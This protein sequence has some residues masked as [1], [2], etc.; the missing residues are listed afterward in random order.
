MR[1][2]RSTLT[3]SHRYLG[4]AI[5]ALV[6]VWFA[7]G[8]VMMYAGGMPRLAPEVR[9]DRIAE[10]DMSRVQLSLAEAAGKAGFDASAGWGGPPVVLLSLMDRP[11]YRFGDEAT[12]FADTGDLLNQVTRDQAKLIATKF[13][14]LPEEKV[15]YVRTLTEVDQW[16]LNERRNLPQ[17]KF[18]ADDG[19][20]TELYVAASN[21][22]VSMLSTARAR[23]LAYLG[24]IPHWLY[25]TPLR[26]QQP[27]WYDIMVWGSTLACVLAVFG[28]VLGFV[29][30]RWARP[31][32]LSTAI[33]YAGWMRWHYI[34]GMVFGVFTLTF[35]FS[36]LLSME[37]YEWTNARGLALDR[38]VF[39]GGS[40]DFAGYPKA[41]PAVWSRITE[42]RGIKEVEFARI[43][44]GH[45]YLVR[46][47]P[48]PDVVAKRRERLH[49]PY[50][51]SGR[52]EA[53]RY[54]VAADT[55][56]VR[57]EAFSASSLVARLKSA[58]PDVP[59][60]EQQMLTDYDDYYYSRGN[61]TPL[62]VLRVKFD[63]PMQSWLYVDPAMSRPLALVHRLNRV[64]RWLFNGL[65]SLDFSFWYNSRPLWDIAML[66][67]LIGGLV[68]S[69]LGLFLGIGRIR[70]ATTRT[71]AGLGG[72]GGVRR[73]E[74]AE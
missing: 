2:I 59:I 32:K 12:V 18:A 39:T 7:S 64:E 46:P 47:T 19:L 13:M 50:N 38:G 74:P 5:A 1:L 20:G 53:D 35:A 61:V 73:P 14:N 41:E 8:I 36:G 62:P 24:V 10:V 37:P 70:R 15:R 58:H 25:F 26:V 72:R 3:L 28:I 49:Q 69:V 34:T 21:G 11:A 23:T 9:L 67:L 29:K 66:T 48:D 60:V 17:Y 56:Q 57:Q 43:Q 45:Y 55:M 44:D 51:V 68:S 52:A 54:L 63:D 4:I 33:P 65:H 22:E 16:T 71:L 6:V 31:F 42:G 40:L 27:I 30:L